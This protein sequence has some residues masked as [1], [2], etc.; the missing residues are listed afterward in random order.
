M[1][2]WITRFFKRQEHP[3]PAQ[4]P[5]R[6]RPDGFQDANL[7]DEDYIFEQIQAEARGGHFNKNYQLP[8]LIRACVPS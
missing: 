6:R 2:D 5:A 8:R 7:E 4:A 3:Q 1:L